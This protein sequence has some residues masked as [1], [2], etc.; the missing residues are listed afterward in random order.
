M[1]SKFPL[2]GSLRMFFVYCL[3][4]ASIQ[5][6]KSDFGSE[7]QYRLVKELSFTYWDLPLCSI[8]SRFGK[9]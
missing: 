3:D 4:T 6:Q 2:N 8:I 1:I 7:I 9:N 5:K